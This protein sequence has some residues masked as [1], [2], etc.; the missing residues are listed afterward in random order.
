MSSI[1]PDDIESITVLKGANAAAL[2]GSR[3]GN[4]VINIITKKGTNRKGIGLEFNSNFVAETVMNLSDLQQKYGAGV[5]QGGVATKPTSVQD[6]FNWGGSSW[7]PA[8]D[9][10]PTVDI[11]G[12]TRSYSY[13]GD[14][15]DRF[16]ETGKSWT[17]SVAITGGGDKQTFRFGVSDLRSSG[18]IPNSEDTIG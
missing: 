10:S 12:N 4:G 7:G 16:Y 15:W 2:Y 13:A 9:G 8:L 17:N 11:L 18:V 1:N 5:Y 3:G 14:N 6:A